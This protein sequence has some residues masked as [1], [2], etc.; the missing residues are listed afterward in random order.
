MGASQ[1][2]EHEYGPFRLTA[3][4]FSRGEVLERHTHERVTFGVMLEGGFDLLIGGRRLECPAGTVF[5]EPAGE[6]HANEI[7]TAGARVL[8]TQPDPGED[9]PPSCVRLLDRVNHF[10]SG[11]IDRIARRLVHELLEPD[12][13]TPLESQALAL[14]MLA[15]A[16]RLEL[17]KSLRGTSPAWLLRVEELIHDRF[18]ESVTIEELADGAGVHPA[19]L[20]RVF[21]ERYGTS[22]GRYLRRLRLEWAAER[23]SCGTESV[24]R[25]ALEA[26]FA[27]QAHFTRAFRRHWG[28][29]PAR[30]RRLRTST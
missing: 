5:T 2:Q 3:A 25:V 23:L 12:E 21:R 15:T 27:D 14:E 6:R 26:G 17:T 10:R 20:T 13:I 4:W 18:R 16:S 24:S 9:F 29:P 1:V 19:H 8:V 7:G 22:P 11:A 30:Y 28:V